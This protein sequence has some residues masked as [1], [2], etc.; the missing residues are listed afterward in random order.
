MM[1]RCATARRPWSMRRK[2][3]QNPK[4]ATGRLITADN[5]IDTATGT[6]KMKAEFGNDNG[7]LFPTSS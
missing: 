7:A 1:K 4:L 2:L 6:V 3:E 5:R